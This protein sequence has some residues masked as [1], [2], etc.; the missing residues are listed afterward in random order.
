[1]EGSR[2]SSLARRS[3][4]KWEMKELKLLMKRKSRRKMR[5][6]MRSGV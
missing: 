6:K 3:R 5:M 1:M 4:Q 2:L